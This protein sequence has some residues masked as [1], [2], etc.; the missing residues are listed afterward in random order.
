MSTVLVTGFS[1]CGTTMAMTMLAHGGFPVLGPYPYEDHRTTCPPWDAALIAD[2]EGRAVKVLEPLEFT[3]PPAPYCVILMRRNF[4]AQAESHRRFLRMIGG[5][6]VD[7]GYVNR[8][9]AELPSL[10][11]KARRMFAGWGCEVLELRFEDVICEPDAAADR[12]V[13]FVGVPLDRKAM[14]A[15]VVCRIPGLAPVLMEPK[16][17]ERFG[18]EVP[19]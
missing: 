11:A 9:A 3:P 1:R 5:M 16:L 17:L 7:R 4:T 6:T 2:A 14:A 12:L 18:R 10:H 19:A 8:L 13:D 15:A